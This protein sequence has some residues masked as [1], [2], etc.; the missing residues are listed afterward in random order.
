VT[1]A[2]ATAV[3][4][5]RAREVRRLAAVA[6][7]S[8]VA[9]ASSATPIKTS[10]I[11]ARTQGLRR[12]PHFDR[13]YSKIFGQALICSADT[14]SRLARVEDYSLRHLWDGSAHFSDEKTATTSCYICLGSGR[15]SQSCVSWLLWLHAIGRYRAGAGAGAGAGRSYA[16]RA[17]RL[18]S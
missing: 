5:R 11:R 17:K 9:I 7:T 1:D 10:R 16:K 15:C 8:K 13:Y 12:R 3:S 6:S 2:T 18:L 14:D 4:R